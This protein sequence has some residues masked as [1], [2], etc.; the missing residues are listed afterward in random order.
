MNWKKLWEQFVVILK[1]IV[2]LLGTKNPEENKEMR[3]PIIVEH[4]TNASLA[5]GESLTFDDECYMYSS[6]TLP[7][8]AVATELRCF[9]L[10]TFLQANK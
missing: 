9:L 5:S 3:G 6:S 8:A 10:H 2:K 4:A 7:G 1:L